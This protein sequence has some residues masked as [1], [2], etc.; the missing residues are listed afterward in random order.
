MAILALTSY[1]AVS[2][3]TGHLRLLTKQP[4]RF[5]ESEPW[6]CSG[7]EKDEITELTVTFNE[8]GGSMPFLS[9]RNFMQPRPLELQTPITIIRE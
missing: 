2:N 4:A 9:Q 8:M 3:W 6:L 1:L 7:T 5:A